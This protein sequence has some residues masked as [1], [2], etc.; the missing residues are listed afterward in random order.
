[1][2]LPRGDL[3]LF[4]I[5][6]VAQSPQNVI[7]NVSGI[8]T[9]AVYPATRNGNVVLGSVLVSHPHS[10]YTTLVVTLGVA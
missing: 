6:M 10:D 5:I 4:L 9:G 3:S 1:M 7:Q 2:Y 8:L